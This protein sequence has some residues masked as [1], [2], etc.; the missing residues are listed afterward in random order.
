MNITVQIITAQVE[1]EVINQYTVDLAI[2]TPGPKGDKAVMVLMEQTVSMVP[3]AQM[4]NQPIKL[5]W[6]TVS[7]ERRLNG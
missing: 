2:G 1:A 6:T 3:M 7:L 4:A 5:L